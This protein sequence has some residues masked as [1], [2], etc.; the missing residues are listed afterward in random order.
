MKG[1]NRGY[2]IDAN[3]ILN[4]CPLATCK[5]IAGTKTDIS[6]RRRIAMAKNKLFPHIIREDKTW[7]KFCQERCKIKENCLRNLVKETEC[8][9]R[10]HIWDT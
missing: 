10:I 5:Y 4:I 6:P 3:F 7:G 8:P 9:I 1:V 2:A